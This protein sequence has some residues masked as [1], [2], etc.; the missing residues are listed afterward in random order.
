MIQPDDSDV[1]L[2]SDMVAHGMQFSVFLFLIYG[3][4]MIFELR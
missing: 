4:A 1:D 3:D 2:L